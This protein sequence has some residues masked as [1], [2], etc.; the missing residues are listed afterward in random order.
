MNWMKLLYGFPEPDSPA[1][2]YQG[3]NLDPVRIVLTTIPK[4]AFVIQDGR[5]VITDLS[6]NNEKD[7]AD[8]PERPLRK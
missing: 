2:P 4:P 5:Y 6:I 8:W 3:S 7:A 1:T